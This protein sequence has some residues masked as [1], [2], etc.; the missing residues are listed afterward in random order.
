[1]PRPADAR[2]LV[3]F[4]GGVD[5]AVALWW[6]LQEGLKPA[7]LTFRYPGRPRGEARAAA[8]LL[9]CAGVGDSIE[10]IEV[11]L[12]FLT[13]AERP[14]VPAGY[15]PSRNAL[16]YSFAYHLAASRGFG[17]ILG[18]HNAEDAAKFPD[19]TPAFFA[20]L[21]RLLAQGLVVEAGRAAPRI[22]MPLIGMPKRDVVA[23]GRAMGV[24]LELSWSC[25][26]DN[27]VPCGACPGCASLPLA[28]A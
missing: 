2:A 23:R 8:D 19:A 10:A 1:M 15:V 9:R 25:Y 13:E 20:S 12:P 24:P 17:R 11:D 4:S 3:L 16:F 14:Q 27:A 28:L 22:E 26:E 21:E 7:T 6:A 5:S 18:G